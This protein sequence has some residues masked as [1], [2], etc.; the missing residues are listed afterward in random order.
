M[1]TAE[2]D[3]KRSDQWR[4]IGKRTDNLQLFILT[5]KGYDNTISKYIPGPFQT[6]GLP[7]C[8]SA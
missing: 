5:E 6:D 1:V 8:R 2:I 3:R 7:V 4:F